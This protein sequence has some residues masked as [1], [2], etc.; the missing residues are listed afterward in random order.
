MF[1]A[2]WKLHMFCYF[3]LMFH[4]PDGLF[5]ADTHFVFSEDWPQGTEREVSCQSEK[6]LDVLWNHFQPDTR[7]QVSV[8]IR[9]VEIYRVK[10]F[11]SIRETIRCPSQEFKV[12]EW[13]TRLNS[14]DKEI[15]GQSKIM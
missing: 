1:S 12:L 4:Y 14:K 11:L 9:L 13:F 2:A 7:K 5:A 8:D 10:G 3:V 15:I 6:L